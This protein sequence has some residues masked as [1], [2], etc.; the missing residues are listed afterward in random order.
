MVG[1]RSL[2]LA[3]LTAVSTGCA[4]PGPPDTA[5]NRGVAAYRDKDYV[6]AREEWTRAVRDGNTSAMN[7]LGYLTFH[8]LGGPT[9]W[10]AAVAL[11]RSAVRGGHA[12]SML[13]LGFAFENGTGVVKDE[14]RAV[15]WYTCAITTAQSSRELDAATR[16]AIVDD[17]HRFLGS[18]T[19]RTPAQAIERGRGLAQ[20]C[21]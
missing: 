8:G 9:D 16:E 14:V 12:E 4:A 6:R 15:G 17:A 21:R 7:N 20:D 5:Y 1:F 11:W 2:A 19:L 18:L 3:L 13:H 10:E